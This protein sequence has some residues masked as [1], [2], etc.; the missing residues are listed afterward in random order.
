MKDTWTLIKPDGSR[1]EKPFSVIDGKQY[2]AEFIPRFEKWDPRL[3]YRRGFA[4]HDTGDVVIFEPTIDVFQ[5]VRRQVGPIL[6]NSGYRSTAYQKRLWIADCKEHGGRP[7]GEVA[8]PGSS[9]H[10]R[11]A[12]MDCA[13]PH[14]LTAAKLAELFRH[15][16]AGL[17]LGLAR[18]GFKLYKN[19]FLH[20]DVVYLLFQPYLDEP[21]PRK[22]VWRPGVIW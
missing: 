10:E 2:I 15:T 17:D 3:G 20:W 1:I 8:A 11:G 22:K 18:T 7:S 12:A 21:N 19:R 4:E 6:I 16:A 14:H 13:I 9:P 5:T